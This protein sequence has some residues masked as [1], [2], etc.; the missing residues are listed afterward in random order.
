MQITINLAGSRSSP[1]M[2]VIQKSSMSPK[3]AAI[4]LPSECII[5]SDEKKKVSDLPLF[6]FSPPPTNFFFSFKLDSPHTCHIDRSFSSHLMLYYFATRCIVA[7]VL[8]SEISSS[9]AHA[10]DIPNLSARQ[11]PG[12]SVRSLTCPITY[13]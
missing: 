13:D 9:I 11:L 6:L 7:L 1:R 4:V 12:T 5:T 8:L 2:S 3:L 10:D